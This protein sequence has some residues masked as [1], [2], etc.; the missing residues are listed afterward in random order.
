M[1]RRYW[2]RIAGFARKVDALVQ[3]QNVN[4]PKVHVVVE[5]LAGK[6]CPEK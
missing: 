3:G 1:I 4:R 2:N 5:D 6:S